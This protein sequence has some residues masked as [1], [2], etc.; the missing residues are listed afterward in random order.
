M[1]AS[2]TDATLTNL[3]IPINV[4]W[5]FHTGS[6]GSYYVSGGVSTLAYVDEKYTN[7]SYRQEVKGNIMYDAPEESV[8][9][10]KV[11][12]VEVVKELEPSPSNAFDVAGRLN[13]MNASFA[14]DQQPIDEHCTCYTCCTFSRAYLRHLIVA[15][16]MLAATLLSI[17]NLHTL[18]QLARDL[19]QAILE[20]R[21]QTF[22][23]AAM[24]KLNIP[25]TPER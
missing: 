22:A 19:R 15:K 8:V 24:D 25:R 21:L 7:T 12:N 23:D 10:Y 4:T 14:E 3:D 13:L 16:E 5:R 17:H 1:P 11:E 6:S 2:Y 20:G 9:T 18:L